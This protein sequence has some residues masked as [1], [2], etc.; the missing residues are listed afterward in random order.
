MAQIANE[1]LGMLPPGELKGPVAGPLL[2]THQSQDMV[3]TPPTLVPT[4][5]GHQFRSVNTR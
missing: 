5:A 1:V 3:H 4:H 2:Q